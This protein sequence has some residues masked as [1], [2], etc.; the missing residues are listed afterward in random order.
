MTDFNIESDEHSA[1][2]KITG[3]NTRSRM[4]A[5]LDAVEPELVG[6]I[7]FM[8]VEIRTE[9]DNG[10]SDSGNV[11]S[12]PSATREVSNAEA[13]PLPSSDGGASS[14]TEQER[15]EA[16]AEE[17]AP[18]EEDNDDGEDE[19]TKPTKT[20]PIQGVRKSGT[21]RS[22]NY[23]PL[24]EEDRERD[25][26]T[27]TSSYHVL[28]TLLYDAEQE[29]EEM[30]EVGEIHDRLDR[31]KEGTIGGALTDLYR[32]GVLDRDELS[33]DLPSGGS[34]RHYWLTEWGRDLLEEYGRFTQDDWHDQ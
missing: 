22:E 5:I 17:T 25:E 13:E 4:K 9:E 8:A 32:R 26:F 27:E 1:S 28:V 23:D 30:L 20:G 19:D 14:D 29:G 10:E 34:T 12:S 24:T 31:M 18:W 33:Y 11:N 6:D 15:D 21:R 7:T 3:K 16:S 2:I